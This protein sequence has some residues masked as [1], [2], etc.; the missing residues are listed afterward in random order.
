MAWKIRKLQLLS[1]VQTL[2]FKLLTK[3]ETERKTKRVRENKL[4]LD[5]RGQRRCQAT[6]VTLRSPAPIW[7]GLG[8]LAPLMF[9]KPRPAP[10]SSGTAVGAAGHT[11]AGHC[12]LRILQDASM[13][14]PCHTFKP[15]SATLALSSQPYHPCPGRRLLWRRADISPTREAH[16]QVTHW[17]WPGLR[18]TRYP[19]SNSGWQ[20]QL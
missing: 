17:C 7:Q 11:D 14:A 2:L 20:Q 8:Q 15:E 6:V 5:E 12:S 19:I 16:H 10:W 9:V 4:I 18:Y 1:S 3:R 13:A